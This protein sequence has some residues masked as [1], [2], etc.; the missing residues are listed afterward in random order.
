MDEVA[1]GSLLLVLSL[2]LAL[3]ATPPGFPTE[4]NHGAKRASFLASLFFFLLPQVFIT[5]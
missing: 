4:Q 5:S 2:A 1:G 3:Q